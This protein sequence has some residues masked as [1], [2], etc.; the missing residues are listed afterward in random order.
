MEPHVS[1]PCE[2][3]KSERQL[4][5]GYHLQGMAQTADQNTPQS[6]CE[7]G[8]L[9]DLELQPKYRLQIYHKSKGYGG[10]LREHRPG[11]AI[12]ALS[13]GLPTARQHDSLKKNIDKLDINKI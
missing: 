5:T 7:K 6:S 13:L 2:K 4:L 8:H 1:G 9:L 3:E 10:A 11:D 12:F